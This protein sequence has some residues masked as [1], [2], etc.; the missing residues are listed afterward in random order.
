MSKHISADQKLQ[1]ATD[2]KPSKQVSKADIKHQSS[3]PPGPPA[4]TN[5][6]NQFR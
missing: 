1:V 4:G 2:L 6:K 5:A 3:E